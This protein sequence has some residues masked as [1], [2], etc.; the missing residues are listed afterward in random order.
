MRISKDKTELVVTCGKP[1]HCK[2]EARLNYAYMGI[3][4]NRLRNSSTYLV[5][6]VREFG[7]KEN[8][9]TK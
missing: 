4:L 1:I 6:S 5:Y 9:K 7:Y 3:L 8:A 2:I